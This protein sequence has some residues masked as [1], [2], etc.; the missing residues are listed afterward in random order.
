MGDAPLTIVMTGNKDREVL[1]TY[2]VIA[3]P[4]TGF[5]GSVQLKLLN[6]YYNALPS[7]RIPERLYFNTMLE[8][9][10]DVDVRLRN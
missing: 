8:R 10:P 7:D 5:A 1:R 4:P 3:Y 9:G 2:R 6:Y